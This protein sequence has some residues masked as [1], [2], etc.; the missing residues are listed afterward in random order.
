MTFGMVVISFIF[1]FFGGGRQIVTSWQI[2]FQNKP[3][4]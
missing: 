1:I 2:F 3:K 4:I